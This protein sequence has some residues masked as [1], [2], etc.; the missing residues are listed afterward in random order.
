M[1]LYV[2]HF[3]CILCEKYYLIAYETRGVTSSYESWQFV[4][5]AVLG[6]FQS[7]ITALFI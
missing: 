3:L 2:A 1:I 4:S 5:R 7:A 6:W